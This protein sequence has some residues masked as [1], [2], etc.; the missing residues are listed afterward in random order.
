MF[1]SLVVRGGVVKKCG[2]KH[3]RS[4]QLLGGGKG[5]GLSISR[6]IVEAR[7]GRSDWVEG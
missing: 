7:D 6:T 3:L 2:G 1:R 5:M 4:Q